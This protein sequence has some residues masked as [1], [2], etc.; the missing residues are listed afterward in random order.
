MANIII[1]NNIRKVV[2]EIDEEEVIGN[3]GEEVEKALEEKVREDLKKA[4]YRA[5]KNQRR[6]LFAKDL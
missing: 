3:V 1:K 6:T 4:I 2:K 5:K